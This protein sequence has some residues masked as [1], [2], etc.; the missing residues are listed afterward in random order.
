VL[1]LL[2]A[3]IHWRGDD[4]QSLS[5]HHAQLVLRHRQVLTCTLTHA[6]MGRAQHVAPKG[7]L[8][9]RRVA[10]RYLSNQWWWHTMLS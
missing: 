7:G 2:P 6:T 1:S 3:Y 10:N 8:F 5:G 9:L 4:P